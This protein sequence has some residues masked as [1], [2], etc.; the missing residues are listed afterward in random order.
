LFLQHEHDINIEYQV[1]VCFDLGQ[2]DIGKD[3]KGLSGEMQGGSKMGSNN[4]H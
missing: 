1:S 4:A 3:L 2:F